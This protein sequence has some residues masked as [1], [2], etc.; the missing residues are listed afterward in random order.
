MFETYGVTVPEILLPDPARCDLAKWSVVACDQ[1]TSQPDYWKKVDEYVGG[2]PSALRLVLPEAYLSGGL[3]GRAA[4]IN[5]KMGE[6]LNNNIFA[7]PYRGFILTERSFEGKSGAGSNRWGLI[8]A[9]DL[10]KYSY[11]PNDRALIRSSEETVRDRLPPRVEIRRGAPLELPH[12]LVLAD[13]A[14]RLL[15]EPLAEG[16]KAGLYKKAYDFELM[17]QGGHIRGYFIGGTA[18][19]KIADAFASL[20]RNARA[21]SAEPLLLAV[22]DGNH[23]LAAAKAYWDEIKGT[24]DAAQYSPARYAL[25]EIINLYSDAV[26]FEPIHRA[27]YQ[28]NH[29]EVINEAIKYFNGRGFSLKFNIG[30]NVGE[31]GLSGFDYLLTYGGGKSAELRVDKP[32]TSLPVAEIQGFIDDF[33]EKNPGVKA[34]YIHGKDELA[35][36]G[37]EEGCFCFKLPP[38]VKSGFF[39]SL[40]AGGV[41]PRKAFSMGEAR[42]KRYYLEARK[43]TP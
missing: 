13:D 1:F 21:A 39:T 15:I 24:T 43:I 11:D 23:S 3:S 35:R 17:E 9:I 34:D 42:E 22:G 29:G 16:A 14:R 26:V 41:M 5:N 31:P 10:D 28:A 12:V 2:S 18:I 33:C 6:Y 20:L 30:N 7:E 40:A 32:L 36:L 4:A 37:A 19:P 25:V 38:V 8:L 27:L